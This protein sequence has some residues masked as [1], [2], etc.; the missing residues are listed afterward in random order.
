MSLSHQ[1]IDLLNQLPDLILI[2]DRS[3]RVSWANATLHNL[4]GYK[5]SELADQPVEILLPDNLRPLHRQQREQYIKQPEHRPMGLAGE[6]YAK[7]KNGQ[8]I[9]VEIEL[10]PVSW[11]SQDSIL[12]VVRSCS[13]QLEKER[14]QQ[15]RLQ[16]SEDRLKRSQ[17]I[18]GIGTWDWG[19][20]ENTLA[21]SDEI[22]SIFGLQPQE[23]AATYEAFLEYIHPD[24]RNAVVELVDRAIIHDQPYRIEHRIRRKDGAIR[25]VLEVGQV[26]RDEQGKPVRM[27]GTV[28]DVT[29]QKRTRTQLELAEIMFSNAYEGI[30]TT[31]EHFTIL[32]ANPAIARM[33][34]YKTD[35]LIDCPLS[36]VLPEHKGLLH[37]RQALRAVRTENH[38]HGEV[39]CKRYNA[40][41]FPALASITSAG[42]YSK[43]GSHFV[44]TLTDIS[45]IK[46]NEEQLNYLAHYDQLTRLPNRTLFLNELKQALKQ[47]AKNQQ[48][49]SLFYID[50]DGFK[51]IN[52]SQGHN[53][54]DELL[55]EVADRLRSIENHGL[56]MARLGGDEFAL[57]QENSN[58]ELSQSLA[59]QLINILRI[60]KQFND[61]R[62]DISA[63]IGIT[64]YPA[65]GS[66]V[67]QLIRQAD[68]A[69]YHAKSLGKN[70]YQHFDPSEGEKVRR[71]IQLISDMHTA[72]Q[73]R[74]FELH[75]QPKVCNAEQSTVQAEALIRWIDPEQGFISPM[76]FIPIAEETGQILSIGEIVLEKACAFIQEWQQETGK[77]IKVAVNLSARQLHDDKLVEKIRKVI[78]D[79]QITANALEFE[80]TETVVM[81]DA[82]RNLEILQQLRDMGST[83]AIDDFGTGYSSLSQLKKLPV[84]TLKIDR[85]FI[86]RLPEDQDD[87]SI[88]NAIIT[89]AHSLGLSLVAEG[90]ETEAQQ[91]YL[92]AKGCDQ[93]QGYYFSKPLPAEA[94]K[95][96]YASTE[97]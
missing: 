33:T 18:A 30:L 56:T 70:N 9:P 55:K 1:H 3:G 8:L 35:E 41:P 78:S 69:M 92:Y 7:H 6:L 51:A 38:W 36:T 59:E 16:E 23:F 72:I 83:V 73:E 2:I 85:S 82:L 52:D 27:L 49:L 88:V 81:D 53:A 71:R 75:F 45:R 95:E 17:A 44:I 21:W 28:Q 76:E 66:E 62:L 19:I 5:L 14:S 11:N 47:S 40:P 4:L 12:A 64:H 54:G 46:E 91:N 39:E 48:K 65:D 96:I 37:Y 29:K 13:D 61:Y 42:N 67:L 15:K 80:I 50:L 24:D 90:V 31:D 68:Q 25:H 10:K 94:F 77:A 86:M 20:A 87:C 89:M 57:F 60:N 79:Y 84:N 63:S 22:Y 43:H 32:A 74:S 58:L 93:L 97:D 34:G 26:Y